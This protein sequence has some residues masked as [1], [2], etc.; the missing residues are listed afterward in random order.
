[1]NIL[2]VIPM[3]PIV[4]AKT[5]LAP[6]LTEIQRQAMVVRLLWT[7]LEATT[8]SKHVTDTWVV[9]GDALVQQIAGQAGAEWH[10]D[11]GGG[12]NGTLNSTFQEWFQQGGEGALFLPADL[13]LITTA[14]VDAII[15]TSGKLRS[16]VFSPATRD[17]GTNAILM[18]RK[19]AFPTLLGVGSFQRHINEASR[20]GHPVAYHFSQTMGFD[21]DTLEDL[22]KW[23]MLKADVFV[24]ADSWDI[25]K[26]RSEVLRERKEQAF[27]GG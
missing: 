7:V 18:P 6:H 17:G 8:A 13:P 23:K 16:L 19:L 20:L 15:A 3:K 1:M 12:L 21:V 10:D 2:A 4:Q 5:R 9:G 27:R 22:Q 11:H 25:A 26:S 24:S 14:D